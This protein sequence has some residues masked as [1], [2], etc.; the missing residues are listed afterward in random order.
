MTHTLLRKPRTC[1]G[2]KT[3]GVTSIKKQ[4][5]SGASGNF[6][7][8]NHLNLFTLRIFIFRD[9]RSLWVTLPHTHTHT[10]E[11]CDKS[12]YLRLF[13]IACNHDY[14]LSLV[15]IIISSYKYKRKDITRRKYCCIP[16]KL[17]LLLIGKRIPFHKETFHN[18]IPIPRIRKY[19]QIS[20]KHSAKRHPARNPEKKVLKSARCTQLS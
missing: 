8:E 6:T 18:H 16:K 1:A 17:Q 13:Q 4:W 9:V 5:T 11:F 20:R 2:C 15:I 10:C 14:L 19:Y 7:R 12:S 3:T